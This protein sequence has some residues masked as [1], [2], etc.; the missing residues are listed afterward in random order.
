MIPTVTVSADKNP[1]YSTDPGNATQDKV[2]LL[3]IT[4][5]NEYF[6][7]DSARQCK[8]TAYAIANG[9]YRNPDNGTCSW[10]LRSPGYKQRQVAYVDKNGYV[11]KRGC[12]VGASVPIRPALWIT[13]NS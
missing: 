12:D 13:L 11:Y 1:E 8:H 3:S 6:S 5:A 9:A 10:W 2:F 7:S 4:E